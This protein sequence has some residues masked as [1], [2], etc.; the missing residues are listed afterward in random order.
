MTNSLPSEAEVLLVVHSLLTHNNWQLLPS[1][2]LAS[3]VVERMASAPTNRTPRE[4]A[5]F[6]YCEQA[7]YPA[8]RGLHGQSLRQLGF[9]E[10]ASFLYKKALKYG[11]QDAQDL[12]HQAIVAI[13]QNMD[14][15]HNPGT[16]LAFAL[17]QLRYC[18]K[19]RMRTVERET[20]LD[21]MMEQDLYGDEPTVDPQ[22]STTA[23]STAQQAIDHQLR[24]LLHQRLRQLRAEFPRA[25]QQWDAIGLRYIEELTVEESAERL[26][27]TTTALYTLVSRAMAKLREDPAIV[28]LAEQRFG[29]R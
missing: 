14:S 3:L 5:Y 7:L 26:G 8:C 1:E 29:N 22:F 15:C 18:N 10:L 12:A 27:V 4:V 28:A 16:F 6:V 13:Y 24:T 23:D 21:E 25:A 11:P 19:K 20:S 9:A 2:T 17:L